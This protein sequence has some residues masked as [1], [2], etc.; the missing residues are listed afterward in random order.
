MQDGIE[1]CVS[2]CVRVCV[3]VSG[4]VRV[5]FDTEDGEERRDTHGRPVRTQWGHTRATGGR[6]EAG[7]VLCLRAS[8]QIALRVAGNSAWDCMLDTVKAV[9]EAYRKDRRKMDATDFAEP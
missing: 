9:S 2:V 4:S 5:F 8:S 1:S 6:L 7:C 3:C